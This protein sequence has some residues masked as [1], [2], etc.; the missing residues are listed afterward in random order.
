MSQAVSA[1]LHYSPGGMS[2]SVQPSPPCRGSPGS[3][4]LPQADFLRTHL[5]LEKLRHFFTCA[6]PTSHQRTRGK[7]SQQ[8]SPM[9]G[10]A[11][12]PATSEQPQAPYK[13]GRSSVQKPCAFYFSSNL[14]L[15][16]G[17]NDTPAQE[18]VCHTVVSFRARAASNAQEHSPAP[19]KDTGAQKQ[20]R[21]HQV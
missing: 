7:A 15:E 19:G 16:R 11:A 5:A 12:A 8:D 14:L 1:W 2:S 6:K 4:G 21:K 9:P 20:S 13:R 10:E 17:G 18:S 3:R